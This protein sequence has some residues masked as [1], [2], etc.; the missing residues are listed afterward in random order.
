[1]RIFEI[2]N[3]HTIVKKMSVP[4]DT[5]RLKKQAAKSIQSVANANLNAEKLPAVGSFGKGK[6]NPRD[7]HEFAKTSHLPVDLSADA[8]Y[9]YVQAIA[10]YIQGNPYLPR[11]YAVNVKQ[12]VSGQTKPTYKIETLHE[13]SEFD[14]SVLMGLGERLF[15]GFEEVVMS[16]YSNPNGYVIWANII[17]RLSYLVDNGNVGSP[18]QDFGL[19][20]ESYVTQDKKLLQAIELIKNLVSQNPNF[21]LDMSIRNAML[22]GTPSGPQLVL[23][24]PIA[25]N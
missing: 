20:S 7:P 10:P 24:D 14:E 15:S 22:R 17:S 11:I 25:D 1:M 21:F 4:F 23:S 5:A 6:V 12:D 19:P 8:Y 13:Y 3:P 9:Q 16:K 18:W 2:I